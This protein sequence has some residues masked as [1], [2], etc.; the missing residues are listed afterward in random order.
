M[1]LKE[2][3]TELGDAFV[4]ISAHEGYLYIGPAN[5]AFCLMPQI[6]EVYS[7][8]TRKIHANAV[9]SLR[10][11]E[12]GDAMVD[13]QLRMQHLRKLRLIYAN[14]A[15]ETGQLQTQRESLIDLVS[16]EH[17]LRKGSIGDLKNVSRSINDIDSNLR[18]ATKNLDEEIAYT[19]KAIN[20]LPEKIRQTRKRI[21]SLESSLAKQ[22]MMARQVR[23]SY[24]IFEVKDDSGRITSPAGIAVLFDGAE[25]GD[26]WDYDEWLH[27]DLI[28]HEVKCKVHIQGV[29]K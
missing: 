20:G 5:E 27:P 22:D 19:A 13:L 1:T 7:A 6:S 8:R 9:S 25:G 11:L 14:A 2:K 26:Y 23:E 10:Y 29:K 17:N 18:Y 28:D 4:Y 15:R 12:S 24:P 16:K 21:A 3:L